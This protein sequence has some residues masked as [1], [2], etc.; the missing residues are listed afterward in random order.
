M[1]EAVFARGHHNPQEGGPKGIDIDRSYTVL[2]A[3]S[4]AQPLAFFD[5]DSL[6]AQAPNPESDVRYE[7]EAMDI[8]TKARTLAGQLEPLLK[9]MKTSWSWR[10]TAPLR[11]VHSVMTRKP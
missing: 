11:R 5:L 8:D 7:L 6:L 3:S 2:A 1:S 10:V 4:E 9:Y